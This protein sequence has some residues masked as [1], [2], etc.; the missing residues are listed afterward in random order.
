MSEKEATASPP[1]S[2]TEEPTTPTPEESTTINVVA[3]VMTPDGLA[4]SIPKEK[5]DSALSA[6][7]MFLCA[8]Y[9]RSLVE[10]DFMD[11][12][13]RWFEEYSMEAGT[14]PLPIQ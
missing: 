13:C 7:E 14:A 1:T 5:M 9:K 4:L 3:L 11:D 6:G 10:E 2:G 8:C 12:M